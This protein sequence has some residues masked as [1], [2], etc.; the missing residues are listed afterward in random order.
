MKLSRRHF[1]HLKVQFLGHVVNCHGV[2]VDENKTLV[3]KSTRTPSSRTALRSFLG[4]VGYYRCFIKWLAE[5]SAS[6]N[7][8]TS[9]TGQISWTNEMKTAFELIK[10]K[11]CSLPVL[12][13]PDF[14]QLLIVDTDD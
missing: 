11:F 9:G 6:L 10:R 3:I 13:F 1:A 12:A 5:I 4:Y 8:S 2:Q 7:Y 14:A